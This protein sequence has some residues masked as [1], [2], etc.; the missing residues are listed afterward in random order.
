MQAKL[1]VPERTRF[2]Q[3]LAI[4]PED[5]DLGHHW[6]AVGEREGFTEFDFGVVCLRKP[7][8]PK[9]K[10]GIADEEERAIVIR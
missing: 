4:T 7:A 1:G 9:D 8:G 2:L 10:M 6:Y 3:E 5:A